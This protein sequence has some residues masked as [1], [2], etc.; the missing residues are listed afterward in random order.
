VVAGIRKMD[1]SVAKNGGP[2]ILPVTLVEF[3]KNQP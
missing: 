1:E 2:R 3:V